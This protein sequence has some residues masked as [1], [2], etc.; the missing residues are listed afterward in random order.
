M[1]SITS[2]TKRRKTA[3]DVAEPK[4]KSKS[5]GE[6][7]QRQPSPSPSPSASASE[8]DDEAAEDVPEAEQN[9]AAEPQKTFKDL[10]W[11]P[12]V[13]GALEQSH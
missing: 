13:D 10:V 11:Q 7:P 3:H 9:G 2:G 8:D 12:C 1:S 5:K 6:K 4:L